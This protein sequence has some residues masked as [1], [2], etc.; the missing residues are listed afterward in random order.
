MLDNTRISGSF[1]ARDGETAGLRGDDRTLVEQTA[2]W[3]RGR[4]DQRHFRAGTRVPSIRAL[5]QL[6]GI[7]RFTVVEAYERLVAHGYLESRR[8]SGFFVREHPG[9][10]SRA[11]RDRATTRGARSEREAVAPT[12][13]ARI[14]A[15][16]LVRNM[17]REL[18]PHHMP[19][20]GLPPPG[21][22]DPE[23]LAGSLRAVGRSLTGPEP[24]LLQYGVPQ[25][26]LALRVELQR[27]LAQIDVGADPTQIVTTS[28]ATQA[29][30][31]IS[32]QFLS[33]GDTV[34]VD[35]P[36]WFLMFALFH[37][38]GAR[39][40]G[41]PRLSDGPD[42]VALERLVV[43]YKP[44]F[45]VLDSVV[46]NP[47]STS[48]SSAKAFQVLK[49]AEVHGFMVVE[50][51]VYGDLHP[52]SAGGG[53]IAMR[54]ASLDQ[55]KRVIY[56]GSFSKTL[57]AN[58]RVAFIACDAELA[59][60][61]ADHKMLAALTTPEIGERMVC[62]VLSDGH[63]RKHVERLR[64]RFD[65]TRDRAIRGLERAGLSIDHQPAQGMFLWARAGDSNGGGIDTNVLAARLFDEGYLLAPGSLFSPTQLPS[66]H[67]RF[68]VATSS[69]PG[70]LDALRRGLDALA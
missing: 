2:T 64:G 35:D 42:L 47:T 59:I 49:L 62:R 60:N 10:G 66:S 15:Q 46:H 31:L 68:N 38:H 48:L 4:I 56:V 28:G 6:R 20:A 53:G 63:Y 25:G 34:L 33:P 32:R 55:L 24:G 57:A 22:M 67:L 70:M 1:A 37:T 7:S 26:L 51:D 43:E 21:W 19:G 61:L 41:V 16:W 17:F 29:F 5:A 9:A 65:A 13:P 30:D 69:N 58:L 44:R 14:D 50:D 12:E 40:I 23:L 11:S 3:L 39:V 45:Y 27:K 36:A 54:L 8:G 52:G 18:P